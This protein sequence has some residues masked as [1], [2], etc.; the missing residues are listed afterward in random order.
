MHRITDQ[1]WSLNG[2]S[3]Q[4]FSNKMTFLRYLPESVKKYFFFSSK[5]Q[6]FLNDILSMVTRTPAKRQFHTT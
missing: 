5:R 6:N 2:S 4:Q 3:I 1:A